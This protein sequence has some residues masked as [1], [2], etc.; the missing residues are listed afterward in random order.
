[1][2]EINNTKIVHSCF[3]Q[4]EICVME[5]WLGETRS[6]LLL[7]HAVEKVSDVSPLPQFPL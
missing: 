6:V 2:H 1:M 4:T 5:S 7:N 3:L